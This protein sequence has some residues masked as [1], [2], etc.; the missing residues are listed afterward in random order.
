MGLHD[1]GRKEQRSRI[2]QY[3]GDYV[4]ME[5]NPDWVFRIKWDAEFKLNQ[6]RA[7]RAY[8]VEFRQ[9]IPLGELVKILERV[10]GDL[11]N[12]FTR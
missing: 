11:E 7:S 10:E 2:N 3:R 6:G 4:A 9:P 12:A 1:A 5:S 8:V